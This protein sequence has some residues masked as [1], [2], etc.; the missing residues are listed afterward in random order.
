MDEKKL[1]TMQHADTL[2]AN[3]NALSKVETASML[4]A[5]KQKQADQVKD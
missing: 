2:S 1:M 4:F 5:Q 3:L